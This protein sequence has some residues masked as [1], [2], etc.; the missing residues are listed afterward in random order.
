MLGSR[1]RVRTL[2]GKVDLR[3]PPGTQNGTRFRIRGQ[4]VEKAGRRGD[5]Y[6]RV[7]VAVP[8]RLDKQEEALARQFAEAAELKF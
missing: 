7:N 1:I 2:D 5:Q 4:G 8:E 6:V 3:I